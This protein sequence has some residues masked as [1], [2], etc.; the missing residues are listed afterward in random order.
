MNWRILARNA[1]PCPMPP[2]KDRAVNS[3]PQQHIRAS[4]EDWAAP[5]G[6]PYIKQGGAELRLL[7]VYAKLGQMTYIGDWTEHW[8][9]L[10]WG[11]RTHR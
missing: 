6:S 2:L 1:A 8:Q 10:T 9:E 11:L 5:Q 3:Q 7:R 4:E